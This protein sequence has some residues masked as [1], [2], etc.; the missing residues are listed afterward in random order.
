M[1]R[2]V[3]DI[4]LITLA[5]VVILHLFYNDSLFTKRCESS[6]PEY[7]GS[8]SRVPETNTQTK[9][10]SDESSNVSSS[11][12][13]FDLSGRSNLK[14]SANII[15]N[16]SNINEIDSTSN[17]SNISNNSN[18]SNN[19]NISNDSN[20]SE[21]YDVRSETDQTVLKNTDISVTKKTGN[22]ALEYN[23]NEPLT[24][25]TVEQKLRD[26]AQFGNVE[27]VMID[28]SGNKCNPRKDSKDMQ[29]YIRDYVLDGQRQCECITDD[30]QASFTRNNV[31]DYREKQIQFRDKIMGS[32]APA[33]DPV[34]RMNKVILNGGIK[35][36]GQTVA[37]FY[38][39]LVMPEYQS[40]LQVP[41]PTKQCVTKGTF[42]NSQGIPNV[43]YTSGENT[44]GKHMLRD[45]WMYNG[46]NPNNGGK[47]F[48]DVSGDD[49]DV[50]YNSI[51]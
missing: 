15:Y 33:E 26:M 32:S 30:T 34:D 5:V 29:R 28:A 25:N 46:E 23:N 44:S 21:V 1:E 36:H 38:D 8:V 13:V 19:S 24:S 45:N 16:D 50:D 12:N 37:S 10:L 20:I 49:Q 14:S 22:I 41:I 6:R 51:V 3:F 43:Y 4:I 47:V 31:D 40:R 17:D 27:E 7:M 48:N 18:T 2:Y 35:A 11:L 9:N 39:N 42:D